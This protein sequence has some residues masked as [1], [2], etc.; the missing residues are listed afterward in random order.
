MNLPDGGRRMSSDLHRLQNRKLYAGAQN[1]LPFWAPAG[2][3]KTTCHRTS[4]LEGDA[5]LTREMTVRGVVEDSSSGGST[6]QHITAQSPLTVHWRFEVGSSLE[7]SHAD[8]I[9]SRLTSRERMVL[10]SFQF[11]KRRTE[12]LLGRLA[13]KRLVCD[14]LRD[15]LSREVNPRAIEV[16]R[17]P[18][19]AP[20]LL[21]ADDLLPWPSG[22]PLPLELSLSH[23]HGAVLCGAFWHACQTS[24]VPRLGVDVERVD[25][26]PPDLFRDYFTES[27]HRYCQDGQGVIRDERATLIWSGKESTLKA[28]DKGLTV[29]TR[30][31]TC[32]PGPNGSGPDT[33]QLV[34]S[35]GWQPLRICVPRWSPAV[36]R[37][38]GYWQT[39]AGFVL[40]VVVSWICVEMKAQATG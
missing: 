9:T 24:S 32:L 3:E 30:A 17:R 19:G 28:L 4:T 35:A 14:L 37:S 27:E 8:H 23:S 1:C 13:A 25:R 15:R 31:V 12:W 6:F 39:Q 22:S 20:M 38:L 29:D 21:S 36:S 33:L 18:S 26:R 16:W 5:E 2:G 34:P 40:T 11:E 7:L 10:E